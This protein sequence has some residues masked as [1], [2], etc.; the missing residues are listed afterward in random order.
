[1]VTEAIEQE[2]VSRTGIKA[3]VRNGCVPPFISEGEYCIDIGYFFSAHCSTLPLL[4]PDS[5]GML[6]LR[7][8]M[9]GKR[10]ALGNS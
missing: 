7:Y 3:S 9:Q 6:D 1:M 10:A 4:K 5:N 2:L 8:R